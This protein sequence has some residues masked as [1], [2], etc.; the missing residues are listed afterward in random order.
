MV[1][2][3]FLHRRS[4]RLKGYDYTSPGAYFVT[5]VSNKREFIFG[6]VIKGQAELSLYGNIAKEEWFSSAKIRR[7]V[8]LHPNELAIMPNHI[9]GIVWIIGPDHMSVG[10]TGQS[11]LPLEEEVKSGPKARSLGSFIGGYKSAVT[12]R[13]N[14]LRSKPGR[15]VWLRNY[16]DRIIRD[17]YELTA[18]RKYIQEN[19]LKWELD[20]YFA[21]DRKE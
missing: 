6:K 11:P 14:L 17:Q 8:E 18:I 7:E 10:A 2:P 5:L 15:S 21:R 13:I 1:P 20:E 19:P 12:K 4:N 3:K 9:H 16:Q